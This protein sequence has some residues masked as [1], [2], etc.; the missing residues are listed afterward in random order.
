ME[1][2]ALYRVNAT[3]FDWRPAPSNRDAFKQEYYRMQTDKIPNQYEEGYRNPINYN[4]IQSPGKKY[5]E[6]D[7][8]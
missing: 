8:Y 1:K 7:G 6:Q 2:M 3:S 5:V 4:I